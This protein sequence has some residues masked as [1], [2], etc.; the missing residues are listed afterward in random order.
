MF[1]FF[2]LDHKVPVGNALKEALKSHDLTWKQLNLLLKYARAQKPDITVGV[3]ETFLYILGQ[4]VLDDDREVTIK[5]V[6]EGL[7]APY[8]TIARQC[9]VLCA[10]PKGNGGLNWLAKSPGSRP[11]TKCLHLTSTGHLFLHSVFIGGSQA[12]LGEPITDKTLAL[13]STG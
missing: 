6:A 9:D 11:K 3:L 2:L 13:P 8:A 12:E 5:D 4:L 7:K 10:G 1:F